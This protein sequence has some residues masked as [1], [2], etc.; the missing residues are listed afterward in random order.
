M[1][2]E[3]VA[4]SAGVGRLAGKTAE[5]IISY[6]AR[7]SS[8]C[9][10]ENFKTAPRL[11]AYCIQEKH[12]S[13]F[14]TVSMT[15]HIRTSR[16]IAAQIIR[17]RSF[18][19][20]EHS[21]RYSESHRNVVNEARRQ[22]SK[23]RQNSIDD[24]T[25]DDKQWFRQAQTDVWNSSHSLYE[26]ALNRGIAKECARFLLPLSTETTLFMTGSVRS[27]IHYIELRSGNGT[28]LEHQAIA[29]EIQAI[30]CQQLPNVA[31][32]L[33]WEAT[34]CGVTLMS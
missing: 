34:D 25:D 6:A 28:Q 20:Q 1:S 24:F 18:T 10:Q 2:V 11:L 33:G 16:A 8:P 14:E 17:H 23:N 4:V 12:Y 5:E 15:V 7:V 29:K 9:N 30:F 3:L 13:I 26:E 19:I 21:M 27:W 32:A 31:K 22:D